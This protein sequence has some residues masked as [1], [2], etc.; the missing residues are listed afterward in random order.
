MNSDCPNSDVEQAR[1]APECCSGPTTQDVQPVES[2]ERKRFE[3]WASTA[4]LPVHRCWWDSQR[5]VY[6]HTTWCWRAWQARGVPTSTG[7]PTK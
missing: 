6:I 2:S 4:G 1:S 3:E 5:Y 7:D